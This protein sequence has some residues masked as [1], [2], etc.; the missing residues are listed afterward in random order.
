MRSPESGYTLVE[1]GVVCAVMIIL[2]AVAV[3]LF[4]SA[5][6]RS[7]ADAAAQLI[8]QEL[9]YARALALGSHAG[10]VVQF[11]PASSEVTVAPAT[12]S[13]RGPFV[14]PFRMRL[15]AAA[16]GPATPDNLNATVL[17]VG[18]NTQMTFLDNGSVVDDPVTNNLISGTFFL[19]HANGDASTR[20]AVTL[21][22]GTGRV[23]VWRYDSTTNSWK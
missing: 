5:T 14:L 23:H 17:G 15:Q 13:V 10:V 11:T 12:G 22:G 7:N 21:V 16:L 2:A 18:D 4:D 6:T 8:A 3:P 19:Q 20:R 9:R 1:M